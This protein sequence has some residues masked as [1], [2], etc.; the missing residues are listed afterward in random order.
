MAGMAAPCRVK[1]KSIVASGLK[2]RKGVSQNGGGGNSAKWR[3]P[4]GFRFN[5]PKEEGYLQKKRGNKT[6]ILALVD[7]KGKLPP[8]NKE[9]IQMRSLKVPLAFAGSPSNP[10]LRAIS[11]M[12]SRMVSM[13]S[14]NCYNCPET[15]ATGGHGGKHVNSCG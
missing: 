12:P 3:L 13:S 4:V 8:K 10:R 6:S 2:V 5:P 1:V 15:K 14:S 11:R 9:Q 7:V